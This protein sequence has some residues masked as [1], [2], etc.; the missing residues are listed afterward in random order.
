MYVCMFAGSDVADHKIDGLM[1]VIWSFGQVYPDYNHWPASG[2][3]AGTA[4]N[5]RFYQPDELKY[6]GS[7]NRGGTT[8]NFAGETLVATSILVL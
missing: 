6:H 3:E 7:R 2:I 8:I 1:V 4:Q 5:E